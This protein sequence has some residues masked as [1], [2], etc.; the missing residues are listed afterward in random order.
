MNIKSNKTLFLDFTS[1]YENSNVLSVGCYGRDNTINVK[2]QRVKQELVLEY[3]DLLS[4][5]VNR[6]S[7]YERLTLKASGSQLYS[8]VIEPLFKWVLA[9]EKAI[10]KYEPSKLDFG[11]FYRANAIYTYEAEGEVNKKWMYESNYYLPNLI[12]PLIKSKYPDIFIL[13]EEISSFKVYRNF[14]LRNLIYLTGSHLIA[15]NR[16]GR[17]LFLKP[18]KIKVKNKIGLLVRNQIQTNFALNLYKHFRDE[19]YFL[20]YE[21]VGSVSKNRNYLLRLQQEF[22][23]LNQRLSLSD[24]IKSFFSGFFSLFQRR[25]CVELK[26]Y[27][28]ALS[29]PMEYVLRDLYI[30][31][32][33]FKLYSKSIKK[34]E[35]NNFISFDML[36][37]QPHYIASIVGRNN[38]LQIQTTVMNGKSQANFIAGNFF[39]HTDPISYKG[40]CEANPHL[41]YKLLLIDTPKALKKNLTARKNEKLN[42]VIYFSQPVELEIEKIMLLKLQDILASKNI[43][44]YIKIHPRQK[45]VSYSFLKNAKVVGSEFDADFFDLALTRHSS[46]AIDCW[47]ANL[48]IVFIRETGFMQSID[49]NYLPKDYIGDLNKVE[50]LLNII[51]TY[52]EFVTQYWAF[53][54][55]IG[56]HVD[57][58]HILATIKKGL[59]NEA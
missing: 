1:Q 18:K 23:D 49:A 12:L 8:S 15:I 43:E 2:E 22:I 10:D 57:D 35:N 9:I 50:E 13:S 25:K 33:D 19:F 58:K 55:N 41:K 28:G 16:W 14:Y 54:E 30:R 42:R 26:L 20:S 31:S 44:F 46:I 40:M 51:N 3:Q 38:I 39:V 37:P 6:L 59:S 32:L 21:Q 29:L 24:L 17:A 48:P 5:L 27:N 34:F 4:E 45:K 47:I 11:R 56:L 53:R 7:V 52:D 36:T